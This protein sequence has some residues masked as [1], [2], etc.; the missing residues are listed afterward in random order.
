[1]SSTD[2]RRA[3]TRF[4][5]DVMDGFCMSLA[6]SVPGVSG[7]TV[8][9]ILGFYE[10]LLASFQNAFSK[11]RESR[12]K[13]LL[14]L[15]RIGAGWAVG[16]GL[17]VVLLNRV[18]ET[19]VYFLSSIFMGL[20]VASVPLIIR[21]E[22]ATLKA[23]KWACA[24][25]PI[26]AAFVVSICLM[27]GNMSFG[28]SVDLS[29]LTL[30][31]GAY[32]FFAGAVGISAMALPGISGSSLLMILGVYLPMLEAVSGMLS[33]HAEYIPGLLLLVLGAAAG[34]TLTVRLIR[35]CLRR[36]R[37]QT[38]FLIIGL[39]L[40]S[41]YAIAMGPATLDNPSP[42]MTVGSVNI[43][44]LLIGV[45]LIAALELI[46]RYVHKKR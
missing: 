21:S 20:T 25:V 41:L 1:M 17:C 45:S 8:A 3:A 39:L 29:A 35:T 9:F 2:R 23:K 4:S 22:A 26:G 12:R 46:R 16:M 10:R 5:I 43:L 40:G 31:L 36:Y 6:D 34:I 27:R 15:L 38:V 30:P 11:D 32:L 42:A 19:H 14:Y 44:G 13:A 28:S 7:G 33:L 24:F 37:A 18:F